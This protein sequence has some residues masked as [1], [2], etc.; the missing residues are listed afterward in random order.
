[1]CWFEYAMRYLQNCQSVLLIHC[2]LNEF[3]ESAIAPLV[4]EGRLTFV[5][6]LLV[7]CFVEAAL[8]TSCAI[9]KNFASAVAVFVFVKL[10][11]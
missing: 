7:D 6:S 10:F 11:I 3:R 9:S 2:V 1:M 8:I 5:T 4:V